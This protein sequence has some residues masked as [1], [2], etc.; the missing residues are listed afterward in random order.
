MTELIQLFYGV[1]IPS[2]V[3]FPAIIRWRLFQV[4]GIKVLGQISDRELY[5][6]FLRETGFPEEYEGNGSKLRQIFANDPLSL[7]SEN[8]D[9]LDPPP[10]LTADIY[11]LKQSV[12]IGYKPVLRTSK[13]VD[14]EEIIDPAYKVKLETGLKQL[15]LDHFCPKLMV[16]NI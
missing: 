14:I 16:I 7:I 3:Y 15:G 6:L 10:P 9:V 4:K 5:Q 13:L 1:V 12:F 8:M 2:D 11:Y